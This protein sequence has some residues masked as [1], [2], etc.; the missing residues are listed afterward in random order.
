M[1]ANLGL[2]RTW[3]LGTARTA[4]VTGETVFHC[5]QSIFQGRSISL[6]KQ[7]SA[8][9]RDY[10]ITIAACRKL[11]AA[12]RFVSSNLHLAAE[13][14]HPVRGNAEEFR[15]RHC[16]AVHGFEQFAADDTETRPPFRHD[17]HS[18]DKK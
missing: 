10:G 15:R 18:A 3:L 17:R 14:D 5:A 7:R 12:W 9:V 1:T 4:I 16:V 6:A 2:A 13:L 11:P 8:Q